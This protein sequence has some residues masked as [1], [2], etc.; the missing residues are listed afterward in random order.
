[1][2]RTQIIKIA[3]TENLVFLS[4]QP[5]P[6][7]SCKFENFWIFFWKFWT[8][9]IINIFFYVLFFWW[10]I[11]PSPKNTSSDWDFFLGLMDPSWNRLTCLGTHYTCIKINKL[12]FFNL[13]EKS[14]IGWIE[15]KIKLQ[16][17][18]IFIFR[19]MV[20]F[21]TSSPQFSMNFHDNLDKSQKK[22]IPFF[23]LFSIFHI[24]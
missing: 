18:T 23:I 11:S 22:I 8:K 16:I 19:A 21:V 12:L 6:Y 14:G 20:I 15:R 10:G 17:F 4:I 1:M 5:I 7:I 13:H 3:K 2:T 9:K 24:S